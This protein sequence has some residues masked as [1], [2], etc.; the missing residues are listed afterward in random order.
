MGKEVKIVLFLCLY[1]KLA[2]LSWVTSSKGEDRGAQLS[3][4]GNTPTYTGKYNSLRA[5]SLS[6]LHQETIWRRVNVGKAKRTKAAPGQKSARV[7][8]VLLL[9]TGTSLKPQSVS[10]PS[11]TDPCITLS[12]TQIALGHHKE[13]TWAT[14]K[15]GPFAITCLC[16]LYD[17]HLYDQ[18]MNH[19][20]WMGS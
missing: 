14:T 2:P 17:L 15:K 20:L 6:R 3:P 12:T 16:H 4:T 18:G 11:Q 13:G 9:F 7:E 1:L 5:K 10:P 19:S 8:P